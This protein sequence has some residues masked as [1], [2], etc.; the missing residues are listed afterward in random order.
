MVQ[1]LSFRRGLLVWFPLSFLDQLQLQKSL[2]LA[3]RFWRC[4]LRFYCSLRHFCSL[5]LSSF[6]LL[7]EQHIWVAWSRWGC[8]LFPNSFLLHFI[9][10]SWLNLRHLNFITIHFVQLR[11]I[12]YAYHSHYCSSIICSVQLY[13]STHFG[14]V[15]I[16]SQSSHL[17]GGSV[18]AGRWIIAASFAWCGA[19]CSA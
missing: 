15:Y 16:E 5:S 12:A 2:R 1:S 8:F 19:T 14:F 11:V 7:D 18:G 13:N 4:P 10:N 3:W 17:A 6:C 9:L